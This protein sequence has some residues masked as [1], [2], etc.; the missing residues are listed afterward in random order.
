MERIEYSIFCDESCHLENDGKETMVLGGMMC[1]K[2]LRKNINNEIRQIKAKH[3]LSTWFEIKWTKVSDK[4]MDFYKEL[5]DYVYEN[6]NIIFRAW[7]ATGKNELDHAKFNES[8]HNLWYYK[9]YYYLLRY[10][11]SPNGKYHI[12]LDVKDTLGGPRIRELRDEL[13]RGA[14]GLDVVKTINQIHSHDSDILQLTDLFIGSISFVHQGNHL[15][16][17]ASPGKI[18]LSHYIQGKFNVN[19]LRNSNDMKFNMYIWGPRG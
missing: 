8:S 1:P 11:F 15:K 3:G 17:N 4:K 6:Q 10:Y 5:V 14:F 19:Y 18:N 13:N 9:M 12:L 2:E 7:V 16:E